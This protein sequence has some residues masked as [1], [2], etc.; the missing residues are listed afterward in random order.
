MP[1]SEP[2]IVCLC[3]RCRRRNQVHV[4]YLGYDKRCRHCHN[5]FLV[6][7]AAAESLAVEDPIRYWIEF[8]DLPNP[9]DFKLPGNPTPPR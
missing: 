7:D 1:T 2:L 5:I 3:G 6:R 4:R 8:T 9:Q